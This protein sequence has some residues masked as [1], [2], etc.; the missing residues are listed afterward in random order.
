[1]NIEFHKSTDL[2]EFGS[3][4]Q[5]AYY[6]HCIS[7]NA[8]MGKGIAVQFVNNFPECRDLKEGKSLPLPLKVGNSYLTGNV[9]N[10]V[11]KPMHYHKPTYD[12]ITATIRHMRDTYLIPLNVKTLCIPRIGCGLDMLDWSKVVY[13]LKNELNNVDIRV[14]VCSL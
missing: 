7:A 14:H 9:I 11:T 13:I 8:A 3:K 2:F 10:L 5:D 6:A 1:M 4:I 12:T